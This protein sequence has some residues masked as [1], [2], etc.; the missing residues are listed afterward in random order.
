MLV[1]CFFIKFKHKGICQINSVSF[2]VCIYS[3]SPQKAQP[4]SR[5]TGISVDVFYL[6][7]IMQKLKRAHCKMKLKQ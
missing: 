5:L 7:F 3:L 1:S 4:F 2:A 6:L